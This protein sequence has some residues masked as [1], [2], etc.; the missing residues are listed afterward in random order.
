MLYL[1]AIKNSKHI[2]YSLFYQ[3]FKAKTRTYVSLLKIQIL[4]LC[5]NYWL[6]DGLILELKFVSHLITLSG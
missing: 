1:N 6:S 5:N 3:I 2:Y 4:L